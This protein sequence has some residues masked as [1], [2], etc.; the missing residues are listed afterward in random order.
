MTNVTPE[1]VPAS[2]ITSPSMTR[3]NHGSGTSTPSIALTSPRN[4]NGS[5]V[6]RVRSPTAVATSPERKPVDINPTFLLKGIDPSAILQAYING[7]HSNKMIPGIK[8]SA[9]ENTVTADHAVGDS[10]E[11]EIYEYID[12]TNS[13]RRI[14]TTNHKKYAMVRDSIQTDHNS[15]PS[16]EIC[17]WCRR[18]F[19]HDSVGIP[20]RVER[21][22][23][24]MMVYHVEGTYCTYECCFSKVKMKTQCPMIIREALLK[25]SETLLRTMF[26]S[27]YPDR[28][29]R[30]CDDWTILECNGGPISEKDFFS[31]MHTYRSTP[32][33][34]MLPLKFE[35]VVSRV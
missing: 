35:Y 23:D 4:A 6:L 12:R 27:V 24:G 29:L 22:K 31:G 15:T 13:R 17:Q 7:E 2:H 19:Y 21:L 3:T 25:D 33:V 5:L 32:N 14:V 9:V 28:R 30:D 34:I 20:I 16:G 1:L 10:P 18:R 8:V 11:S 26:H